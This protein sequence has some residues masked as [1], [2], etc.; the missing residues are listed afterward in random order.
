MNIGTNTWMFAKEK[1]T[2]EVKLLVS[3]LH[4][5]VMSMIAFMV[6][7]RGY[8]AVAFDNTMFKLYVYTELPVVLFYCYH[9]KYNSLCYNGLDLLVTRA[10]QTVTAT[11]YLIIAENSLLLIIL[12]LRISCLITATAW[13]TRDTY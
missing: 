8:R 13:R 6:F 2:T 12:W 4:M 7:Y 11:L 10:K 1:D 5:L 9:F 3:I